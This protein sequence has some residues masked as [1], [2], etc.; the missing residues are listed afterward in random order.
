M[1]YDNNDTSSQIDQPENFDGYECDYDAID[2]SIERLKDGTYYKKI[3]GKWVQLAN[4]EEPE[5]IIPKLNCLDPSTS[6]NYLPT[7]THTVELSRNPS[8]SLHSIQDKH[9]AFINAKTN[10]L[11]NIK[12]LFTPECFNS[13]HVEQVEGITTLNCEH[14]KCTATGKH[15]SLATGLAMTMPKHT[16][17]HVAL[18][19]LWIHLDIRKCLRFNI[20]IPNVR[21]LTLHYKQHATGLLCLRHIMTPVT[22]LFDI[23]KVK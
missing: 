10:K 22:Y 8:V 9:F 3:N 7:A 21:T 11:N 15:T 4:E 19:R 17:D 6:P 20:T 5:K 23:N 14:P 13:I 2:Y 18:H 1:S 12:S 16:T